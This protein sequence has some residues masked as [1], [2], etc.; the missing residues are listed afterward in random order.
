M[1]DTG[2][3]WNIPFVA[4]TDNPRLFPAAD[5]AQALAIAAGLSAAGYVKQVVFAT[6]STNRTTTSASLVSATI[7]VTITPELDDSE[8]IVIWTGSSSAVRSGTTG[9]LSYELGI[10]DGS[11]VTGAEKVTFGAFA[12][13]TTTR[14]EFHGFTL[15][16]RRTVTSLT[17]ITFTGQ[18]ARVDSDITV[19]LRNATSTGVM[20]AIEVQ[21]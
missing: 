19:T 18:F 3:P 20:I 5:E 6:D 14:T 17:P 15:V 2:A 11:P 1:P 9:F 16:G 4:P 21:S 12:G 7:S 10:S 13:S 8:I